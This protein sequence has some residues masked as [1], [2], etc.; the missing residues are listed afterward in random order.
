MLKK[1]KKSELIILTSIV[2]LILISEYHFVVMNNPMRA[3]FLG[4]WP[5]TMVGLLIYFNLKKKQ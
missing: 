2:A 3:I 5:P 4:L 1:F